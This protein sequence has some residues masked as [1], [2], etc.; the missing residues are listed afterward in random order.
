MLGAQLGAYNR[1]QGLRHASFVNCVVFTLRA[2][3]SFPQ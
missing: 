1:S 2:A 3:L